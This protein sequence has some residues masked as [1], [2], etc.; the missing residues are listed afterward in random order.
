MDRMSYQSHWSDCEECKI[1]NGG[2]DSGH[3]CIKH[4]MIRNNQSSGYNH[5]LFPCRP[6]SD[7]EVIIDRLGKIEDRLSKLEKG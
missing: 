3:R 1:V 4:Q 5:R 6:K 2:Y 7:I